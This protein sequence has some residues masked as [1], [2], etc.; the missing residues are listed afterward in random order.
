MKITVVF[1][2][3]ASLALFE[4]CQ[5][6]EAPSEDN[7][8]S[9]AVTGPKDGEATTA[10]SQDADSSEENNSGERRH[11]RKH[12]KGKGKCHGKGKDNGKDKLQGK[13]TSKP[14][15]IPPSTAGATQ[16]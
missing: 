13:P 3:V 6:Q 1:L 4:L 14:V 9:I 10:S 8:P 7:S 11:G 12:G 15:K 16:S 5:S 2:L